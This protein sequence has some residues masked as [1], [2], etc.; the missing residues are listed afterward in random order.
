MGVAWCNYTRYCLVGGEIGCFPLHAHFGE[1]RN[2]RSGQV[3]R[4]GEAGGCLV[5]DGVYGVMV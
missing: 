2:G 3:P 5:W 1:F 4:L